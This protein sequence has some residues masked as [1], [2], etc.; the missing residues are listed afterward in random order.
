MDYLG[1]R[2]HDRAELRRYLDSMA[3]VDVAPL[4]KSERLVYYINLYNATMVSVVAD[5]IFDG[6]SPAADDFQVF[7]QRLVRLKGK[8][9]SL[10]DLENKVIRKQFK[11]PRI[12]VALVCGA[13]SCPPLIP[14]AYAA[15][16]LDTVLEQNM[17]RFLSDPQRNRVDTQSKR[18]RL[19]QIFE[20]YKSD[21]GG[22]D[23]LLGYVDRYTKP[24]VA[25]FAVA[26]GTYSWVLNAQRPGAGWASLKRKTG[27][28]RKGAY[29]E[30][31]SESGGKV[32][33]RAANGGIHT[34]GRA[35]LKF[36]SKPVSR[37]RR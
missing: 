9:I 37:P 30:F 31:I 23:G 26:F 24:A 34:L 15:K 33:V 6:Y 29:V 20:W 27:S 28:L 2:R 14:R 25:G 4:R 7:K 19:S 12:H 21:F 10:N 8:R 3:V 1:I 5:R 16:D 32:K 13:V 36:W 35:R 18:L 17:H 11:E 22:D